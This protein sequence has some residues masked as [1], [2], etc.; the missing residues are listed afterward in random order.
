MDRIREIY[1]SNENVDITDWEKDLEYI[2]DINSIHLKLCW[3]SKNVSHFLGKSEYSQSCRVYTVWLD[4][5][6]YLLT[7]LLEK[8]DS[9][10]EVLKT[11][12]FE[13][14]I[15]TFLSMVCLLKLFSILLI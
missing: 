6:S 10:G 2:S 9:N 7:K 12:L 14:W 4:I 3:I 8:M 1:T 15:H 5:I 11:V 13:E